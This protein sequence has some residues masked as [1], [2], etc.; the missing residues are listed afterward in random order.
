[1]P[2]TS[3]R[4]VVVHGDDLDIAT[5]GRGFW[6]MD[7]MAAL[8]QIAA[9][10]GEVL[11]ANA[12]LFQP[13]ETFA[14]IQGGMDGTPMPHEDP[15]LQNPPSGVLVY[16]WLKTAAPGPVKL[17]LLD[18]AGA[19]RACAA[20]DQEV[21]AVNTETLNVQAIWEQPAL[22]PSGAVG[23]HRF[24]LNVAA[25]RGFGGGGGFGRGAAPAATG[26]C[27]STPV[28]SNAGGGRPNRGRGPERL[29]PGNYTVE[30]TVDGQ[31]YKQQVTLKADPRIANP[32][33]SSLKRK[34]LSPKSQPIVAK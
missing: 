16:Y 23:M 2:V 4:D 1:M 10:G 20:S 26:A 12:Y 27:A 28:V 5:Y 25:G 22:P 33:I 13:G 6:V 19:V 21:R 8:R 14:V 17:E 15:Q 31:T 18:S 29:Q 34:L 32:E 9:K 3:V 30:M 7:Q 24:A 11:S